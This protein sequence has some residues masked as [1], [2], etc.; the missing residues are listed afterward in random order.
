M[1][2]APAFQFYPGDWFREPGLK[3]VDLAVRGAWAELL[4][5]MWDTKP[6]GYI[7]SSI[8][9]F[10]KLWRIDPKEACFIIDELNINGIADV[11]FCDADTLNFVKKTSA[12]FQGLTENGPTFPPDVPPMS[13]LRN[14]IISIT[15]RR[16][17]K[18]WKIKEKE[19]FKKQRQREKKEEEKEVKSGGV[20]EKSPLPSSSS[21]SK[22]YSP[23]SNAWRL[24]D[25]L[26]SYIFERNNNF[27]KPDLQKWAI[28]IDR[29][30][31]LD[32]RNPVEIKKVIKWCQQ[33]TFWQNNILSTE[34]L[35][36]QYDQLIMK[37]NTKPQKKETGKQSKAFKPPELTGDEIPFNEFKE[38]SS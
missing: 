34:K 13:P 32:K 2:K 17:Y 4:M 21:T 29:M 35:K 28:H 19:R 25:L 7:K 18:A 11:E 23:N 27:K 31:R 10:A 33:N 6:Q 15:C 8:Y 38:N 26:L 1:G 30:I 5:I 3:V 36:I 20:P 14:A 37:M 12:C 24:S 16:T 22:N 9:G